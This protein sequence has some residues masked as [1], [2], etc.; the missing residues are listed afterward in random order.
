MLHKWIKS[1]SG[2]RADNTDQQFFAPSAKAV[3]LVSCDI[4]C[5]WDAVSRYAFIVCR[6]SSRAEMTQVFYMIL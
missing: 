5:L 3:T 6:L 2:V 1:S 4:P